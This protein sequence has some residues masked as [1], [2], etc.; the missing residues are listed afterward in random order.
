[1]ADIYATFPEIN[2]RADLKSLV[3]A[4]VRFLL[5]KDKTEDKTEEWVLMKL[6]GLETTTTKRRNLYIK[7]ECWKAVV[8]ETKARRGTFKRLSNNE[9][10]EMFEAAQRRVYKAVGK[11]LTPRTIKNYYNYVRGLLR[12][13]AKLVPKS[14]P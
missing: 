14:T 13:A 1:M 3:K 4:K 8:T 5:A 11:W 12:K 7:W 6:K 9:S 2:N 10:E